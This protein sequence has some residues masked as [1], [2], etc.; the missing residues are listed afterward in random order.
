MLDFSFYNP[1]R[2][3]FGK[4]A[5]AKIAGMIPANAVVMLTYGGG[6]I[7]KNGAYQQVKAALGAR[8]VIEFGGIEPNPHYETCIKAVA[9]AKQEKVDFLLAVG[10]GSVVDGTKFIAAAVKYPGGNLWDIVDSFSNHDTDVVKDA[11]PFGTVITLPATGSEMN[12]G[13]VISRFEMQLKLHFASE[14]VFPKFSIINPEF[15]ETLDARQTGNGIVDTFV[16]VAEQ[17]ITY[18]VNTPLI[19][20]MCAGVMRTL[21]DEAPK[22]FANPHD[23]AARANICWC[24]TVGLNGWLGCGV[25]QDWATHMLGHELTAVYG[26]DHGRT[27]AVIMPALWRKF[28]VQKR[29][30]LLFL[31][32][33]VWGL[34]GDSD[35]VVELAITKTEEFFHSL[36]VPT[37]L[38]DYGIDKQQAAE[39]IRARLLERNKVFG[40]HA[41]I[42]GNIAAEILLHC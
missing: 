41:N 28:K 11:L 2:I 31:A 19:D 36:Q 26:L 14:K 18:D 3:E 25:V 15:T 6:S 22:V 32:H 39:K 17:F 16:H 1:V 27:L 21:I 40:E 5:V 4:N 24:S 9:L 10:G 29:P 8:K 34:N 13:A 37:L 12:C 7:F 38:S 30:K 33:E 20:K 23:Y 42:D 35:E